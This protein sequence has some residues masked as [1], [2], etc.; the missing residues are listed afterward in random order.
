MYNVVSTHIYIYSVF[1][2]QSFQVPSYPP[3][4]KTSK[5]IDA[6][7]TSSSSWLLGIGFALST[8]SQFFAPSPEASAN[9]LQLSKVLAACSLTIFSTK[10]LRCKH[11]PIAFS[12]ISR[13]AGHSR[14]NFLVSLLG[15]LV[16]AWHPIWPLNDSCRSPAGCLKETQA[17]SPHSHLQG[18]TQ[19]TTSWVKVQGCRILH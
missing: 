3:F 7:S 6:L 9:V 11:P 1:P 17:S 4:L 15:N 2:A 18:N 12:P 14:S 5:T 10:Q 16:V 8:T 13:E 19:V